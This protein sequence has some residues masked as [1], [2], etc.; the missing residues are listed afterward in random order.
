M[1]NWICMKNGDKS[2]IIDVKHKFISTNGHIYKI[3]DYIK[4]KH[5][6]VVHDHIYIGGYEL[7]DG[8]FT[9]TL[10]SVLYCLF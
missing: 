1:K 10:K 7:I 9:R 2:I 6:K 8:Q 3:P 5:C 4:C